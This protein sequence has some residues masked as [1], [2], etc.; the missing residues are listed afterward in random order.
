MLFTGNLLGGLW[1]VLIGFFLRNGA[2]QSYQQLV[3]RRALEGVSVAEVMSREVITVPADISVQ[4][5]VDD[6]S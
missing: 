5:A 6:Y 1:F 3:M 4:D 2:K